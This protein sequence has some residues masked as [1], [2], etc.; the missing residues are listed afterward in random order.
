[1]SIAFV[2]EINP[3][4]CPLC[5]QPNQCALV[6]GANDCWCKHIQIPIRHLMQ[7]PSPHIGNACI[8]QKCAMAPLQNSSRHSLNIRPHPHT[9]LT[10]QFRAIPCCILYG[11]LEARRPT[12]TKKP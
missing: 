6:Q 8:C 3:L 10:A 9:M 11:C 2:N 5:G 7:I 4:Q 12:P 1:M